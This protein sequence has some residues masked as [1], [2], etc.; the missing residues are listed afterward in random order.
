MKHKMDDM[1]M[2]ALLVRMKGLPRK[3]HSELK[4]E[5]FQQDPLANDGVLRAVEMRATTGGEVV[6]QWYSRRFGVICNRKRKMTVSCCRC[7]TSN[8]R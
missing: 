8:S 3:S 4:V 1:S 2:D 7:A 5:H 6:M